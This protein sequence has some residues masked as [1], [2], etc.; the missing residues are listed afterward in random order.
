M[1][2]P[3]GGQP[4]QPGA[5][6]QQPAFLTGADLNIRIRPG[7]P[8][9]PQ[10]MWGKTIGEAMRY[11]AVMRQEFVR[12]NDPR[13]QPPLR[14]EP[15]PGAPAPAAPTA[16]GAPP[17]PVRAPAPGYV[18]PGPA[19][20]VPGQFSLEDVQRIVQESVTTAMNSSPMVAT[21]AR[22]VRDGLRS[23]IPDWSQ[24]AAEIEQELNGAPASSL[25]DEGTWMA[26]YYYVKGKRM[27]QPGAQP[28]WQAP[29]VQ[30]GLRDA[31]GVI[32]APL[33]NPN[34]PP[35]PPPA[36]PTATPAAAPS[37]PPAAP[38]AFFSEAPGPASPTAWGAPPDRR[39]DPVV[40]HRARQFGISVDEYISWMDGRV[41]P[42]PAGGNYVA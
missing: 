2:N 29:P 3:G 32:Y 21:S 25:I 27:S 6:G 41:P 28:T 4:G 23:R 10:E 7:D 1:T 36:A 26:A 11:Y 31:R 37:W 16:W 8:A 22:T 42:P 30:E 5:P 35:P 39:N 33:P 9:F 12:N 40:I 24:Y 34:A 19:A 13:Q 14:G 17:A 38:A 18:P 20:P 15:A